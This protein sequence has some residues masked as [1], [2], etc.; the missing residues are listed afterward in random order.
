MAQIPWDKVFKFTG[1]DIAKLLITA[2]IIVVVTKIQLFN[3]KLSALLIALPFTSLVAMM[4][5]QAEK[6]GTGRIANHAEGT[7][8]FVLPTLPM[9]LILPWMLR[10]G[11]GFWAALGVNCLLTAGL[12]WATVFILK[13]FGY[14]LM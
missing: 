6:Q 3:D 14:N 11:W 4:W 10:H 9:F 13:R 1:Y 12:F 7:F 2:G 5:M 8:W